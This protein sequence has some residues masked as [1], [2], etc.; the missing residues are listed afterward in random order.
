MITNSS[1]DTENLGIKFSKKLKAGD[2]VALIGELGSGK[3]CFVEGIAK[4][5]NVQDCVHSPTFKIINEYKINNKKK[6]HSPKKLFH[7]DFYRLN[8]YNDVFELGLEDLYYRNAIVVIE[9]ADK[10]LKVLPL[11]FYEVNISVIDRYKR[12]IKISKIIYD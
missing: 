11:S 9:W 2:F 1:K 7:I 10:F 12:N 8:S 6:L 4:G 3:T 5:L